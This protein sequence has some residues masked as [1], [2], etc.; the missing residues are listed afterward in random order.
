MIVSWIITCDN[1]GKWVNANKDTYHHHDYRGDFCEQ[2]YEV[3]KEEDTLWFE[4][5]G[6]DCY[7]K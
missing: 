3:L 4:K 6:D 1:C 2:C 5:R 7:D